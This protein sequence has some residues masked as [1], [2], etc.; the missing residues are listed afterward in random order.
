M[1]GCVQGQ[2]LKDQQCFLGAR[3]VLDLQE[4]TN[5][6]HRPALRVFIDSF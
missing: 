5:V 1:K 2:K 3:T 4:A 6:E